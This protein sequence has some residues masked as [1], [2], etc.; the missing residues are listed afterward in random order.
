MM[1]ALPLP[2]L[3]SCARESSSTNAW[4][5]LQGY[6]DWLRHKADNEVNGAPVFV[7]RSGSLV[8]T[9]S[10]NIRVRRSH[11]LSVRGLAVSVTGLGCYQNKAHAAGLLLPVLLVGV[12]EKVN[13]HTKLR[14]CFA[15]QLQ[16]VSCHQMA[17][18]LRFVLHLIILLKVK[19]FNPRLNI[20]PLIGLYIHVFN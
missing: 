2:A 8:Q 1:L 16:S 14:H 10:K 20:S 17:L 5:H 13:T 4:L 11:H 19:V 15:R 9:R 6:E 7:V 3:R 18:L 12:M